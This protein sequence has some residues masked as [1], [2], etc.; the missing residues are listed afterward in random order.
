MASLT[1]IFRRSVVVLY[2]AV[3][4]ICF[5]AFAVSFVTIAEDGR[6]QPEWRLAV[7]AV[8]LAALLVWR[9]RLNNRALGNP[10]GFPSPAR[11]LKAFM[12]LGVLAGFGLLLIL[13][14]LVWVGIGVWVLVDARHAGSLLM[15]DMDVLSVRTTGLLLIPF[16]V[17]A[18][19]MGVASNWFFWRLFRRKAPE[20]TFPQATADLEVPHD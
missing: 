13:L 4:P 8:V 12:P 14:G 7:G 16:G 3:L 6:Y 17:A 1:K 19:A 9:L 2:W 20:S 15:T 5:L 18:M 11:L 10:S